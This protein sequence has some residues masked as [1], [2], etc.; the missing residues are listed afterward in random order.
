MMTKEQYIEFLISTPV[1][2]TC[3]HLADHLS[4]VSHDSITDFLHT[5]RLTAKSV[6]NTAKHLIRDTE[7]SHLIVDDSVQEK[8]YAKASYRVSDQ[9]LQRQQTWY[10]PW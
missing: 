1:N 3:T 7:D 2:Y 8:P 9:A 6:W 5:Q 4:D 10:R